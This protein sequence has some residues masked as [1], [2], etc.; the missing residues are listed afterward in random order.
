M[1][2]TLA[3]TVL[4]AGLKWGDHKALHIAGENPITYQDLLQRSFEYANK[5]IKDY[6]KTEHIGILLPNTT[7]WVCSFYGISLAGKTAVLLN[8][9]LTI[10]E[11]I[12][13][14]EQSDTEILFTGPIYGKDEKL[15]VNEIKDRLPHIDIVWIG[16]SHVDNTSFVDE[17]V[18]KGGGLI[19]ES[20]LPNEDDTGVILYTSGTTS[21]PKGV[22]LAHKSIIKNAQV[23]GDN[24]ELGINDKIFSAGPFFHSGGLTMHVVISALYGI[25]AYSVSHFNPEL[26]LDFVEENQCTIYSGI[27]TLFLRLLDSP[28]FSKERVSSIRTGWV[29]GSPSIIRKVATEMGIPGIIAI[30]GISEASPNVTIS[31]WKAPEEYRY[32]TV[33]KAHPGVELKTWDPDRKTFLPEN[34][35][36]ELLV[37]GYSVMKGYYKKPEETKRTLTNGWLH[38]GDYARIRPDGYVLFEGRLK[39]IVRIGGENVSCLEVENSIYKI[40]GVE[41]AAVLPIDDELYGQIPVAVIK[42]KNISEEGVKGQLRNKLASYKIPRKVI[43]QEELPLTESGK[44]K[45]GPLR[46]QVEALT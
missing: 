41:I 46:E 22:M 28:E 10:D 14:I 35:T 18:S 44:V 37:R 31:N 27:E 2:L 29:T 21:L 34:E 39:D 23:V 13:Q 8:P 7:E 33:G 12:Y 36:G 6:A 45:K 15:L 3:D 42:G 16:Q 1:R 20:F 19:D 9:R 5:L 38:T 17:W 43:F 4:N 40:K 26:I 32:D 24:F 25:T 30:Y 11:L